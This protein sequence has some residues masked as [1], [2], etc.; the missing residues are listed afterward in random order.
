MAVV[1]EDIGNGLVRTYSDAEMKI[2]RDGVRYDEAI[3]PA[4][5]GR[6]YIETDERIEGEMMKYSRWGIIKALEKRGLADAFD[7]YLDANKA[8][9]RRFYGPSFFAADDPDFKEML[10]TL[11]GAFKLTDEDIAAIL[12]ESPYT[13]DV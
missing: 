7:A 1:C 3:D 8:A 4:D 10:K 6:V 11:Q 5:A 9:F 13:P 12:A 2:E